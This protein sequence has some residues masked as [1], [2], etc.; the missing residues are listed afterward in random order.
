MVHLVEDEDECQGES[1]E[2]ER[3][4][5]RRAPL[6][7]APG[8]VRI[9]HLEDTGGCCHGERQTE[10]CQGGNLVESVHFFVCTCLDGRNLFD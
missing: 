1:H 6:A 2:E 3:A 7:S 5:E 10:E 8:E 9:V 4:H